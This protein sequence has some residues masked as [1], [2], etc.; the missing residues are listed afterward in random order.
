MQDLVAPARTV[1]AYSTF[2]APTPLQ[3]G[4][5]NALDKCDDAYFRSVADLLEG[6]YALLADALRALGLEV[7][8][9]DGGYFVLVNVRSTGMTAIE[10]CKWL[11]EHKKV[12]CTPLFV[13][14][15]PKEDG[16]EENYLLRFAICK[17][18]ATIER[19]CEFLRV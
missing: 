6:N 9:I 2:C 12:A 13:F 4:I 18:R 10:Y 8:P 7:C 11:V 1:H 16:A 19:A 15:T 5:A 3:Q 17:Q 14:Y